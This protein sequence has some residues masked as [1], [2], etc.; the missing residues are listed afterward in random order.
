MKIIKFINAITSVLF[1]N[2]VFKKKY[3]DKSL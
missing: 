3:G 2:F 1:F